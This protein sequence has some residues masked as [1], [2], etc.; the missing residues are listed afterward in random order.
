MNGRVKELRRIKGLSQDAF[1]KRLGVTGAGISKI[2]SGDRKLTEQML[3]HICEC[4][5]VNESW[6][7]TGVGEIFR[8]H[9]RSQELAGFFGDILK[10]EDTAFKKRLMMAL[11][12]LDEKTWAD[13]E[14]VLIEQFANKKD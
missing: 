4:Y 3:L 1:G 9:T 11:S 12:R 7:R 6:L 2:E 14:R 13:V 10:E 5:D 8:E